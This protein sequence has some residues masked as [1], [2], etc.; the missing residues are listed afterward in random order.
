MTGSA[1]PLSAWSTEH[2][3][4]LFS[5]TKWIIP[6]DKRFQARACVR[7][8]NE[9][10]FNG[11]WVEGEDCMTMCVDKVGPFKGARYETAPG[12]PLPNEIDYAG[13]NELPSL[14][15]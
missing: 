10:G 4:E 1:A 11:R 9:L 15:T 7:T 14:A 2:S 6:F 8:R 12:Y 5:L 3:N 13:L